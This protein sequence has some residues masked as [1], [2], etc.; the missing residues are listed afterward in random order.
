MKILDDG[1]KP[2]PE[3]VFPCEDVEPQSARNV[4][5]DELRR[6]KPIGSCT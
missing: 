4:S 3:T 2:E 5:R 6:V 1:K